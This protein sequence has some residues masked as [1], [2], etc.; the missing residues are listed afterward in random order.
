MSKN[1]RPGATGAL[2]DEYERAVNELKN[3]LHSIDQNKYTMIS[4]KE[5][6]DPECVSVM[7]LMNHVVSAGYGYANY[8]RKQF[9]ETLTERKVDY[10]VTTPQI[11]CDE[12]DKM[13]AYTLETLTNKWNI[14]DEEVMKNIIKTRWGQ[15]YDF[16]Q[17]LE[18]AI[19]HILRHRRQLEKFTGK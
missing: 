9:D 8:I 12:L 7:S 3:V 16:E 18:H 5:T 4:D 10:E 19:V 13:M 1:Y 11:A 6:D 17:M 15:N 14:S 2:M